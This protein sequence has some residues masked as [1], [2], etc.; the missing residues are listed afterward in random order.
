MIQDSL[1]LSL[2]KHLP[3]LQKTAQRI[4]DGIASGASYQ[5]FNGKGLVGAQGRIISIPVGRRYRILF[6]AETK[7]PIKLLSHESYNNLVTKAKRL[8]SLAKAPIS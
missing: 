4:I 5:S 7:Q 2:L 6:S 8:S 3:G 1:D